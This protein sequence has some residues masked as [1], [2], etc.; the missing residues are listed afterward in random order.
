MNLLSKDELRTLMEKLEGPCVS[1]FMPTYRTLPETK[2]NTIRFKNL[3]RG[4][5]ERLR[6]C[7][8]RMVEVKKL[9]KP[10]KALIKDSIFWQYQRDGLA[11]FISPEVFRYYRLPLHFE[12]LLVVTDRFHI[13][14]LLNLFSNDARFYILTLSQNKVRLF[15]CTRRNV[16]EVDLKGV[17]RSLGE[18]LKYDEPEKQ[19]QFHTRTPRGTGLRAAIF[20]GQG[21][22]IDDNKDNILRYFRQ[23][24]H[25]LRELLREERA[26]VVLA[27][28]EYLLPIYREAN[29]FFHLMDN[30]IVGN[31]EG[32]RVEELHEQ[33][34]GIVE[35]YYLKEQQ[36]VAAQYRQWTGSERASNDIKMIVPASY[37]GRLDL[38]FVAVGIQQ[39]GSYDPETLTVHLH[40]EAEPGDE[41]LLDFAAIHTFL[42]GGRVYAVEPE[43]V[44]D[45]TPLAALLRY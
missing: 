33:A 17:P 20:H 9:L 13:K 38:L 18:A 12:E 22:G 40:P 31:P 4:A 23:I 27:G 29:T 44:P 6:A 35:P 8:L 7:G 41:D 43:K 11:A 42:N 39:W 16:N 24:D 1:I 10:A 19:L 2:Q 37:D 5:E 3:L 26:P 30:G 21:V 28:V 25:G 14:P 32:V 45:K 34:W 36:E 15:E